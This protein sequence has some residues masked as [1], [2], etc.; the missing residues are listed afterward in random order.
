MQRTERELWWSLIALGWTLSAVYI[1]LAVRQDP[2]APRPFSW[3]DL[4]ASTSSAESPWQKLLVEGLSVLVLTAC[5]A[6]H[7]L[8]H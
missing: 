7:C 6:V 4:L 5:A 1:A 3:R 8:G 2:T